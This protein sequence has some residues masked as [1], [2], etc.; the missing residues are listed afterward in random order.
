MTGKPNVTPAQ[1]AQG[2]TPFSLDASTMHIRHVRSPQVPRWTSRGH[3]SFNFSKTQAQVNHTSSAKTL[4]GPI[5][6]PDFKQI[7]KYLKDI[8]E[9]EC[10]G[11][12][13]KA[14][15]TPAE[16]GEYARSIY[17]AP[18]RTYPTASSYEMAMIFGPEDPLAKIHLAGFRKPRFV[19][20]PFNRL[21]PVPPIPADHPDHPD[22]TPEIRSDV[23]ELARCFRNR[24]A[25]ENSEPRPDPAK[26]IPPARWKHYFH[27]RNS[28][29]S[30]EEALE[31]RGLTDYR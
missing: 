29:G 11:D 13:I 2:R 25:D 3:S 30:L 7:R 9:R 10:L 6:A 1:R 8:S 12:F 15:W 20:P 24:R 22:H 16:L 21:R 4:R 17:L 27:L 5:E 14:G 26:P 23:Q 19:M 18:G 31:R 28:Y